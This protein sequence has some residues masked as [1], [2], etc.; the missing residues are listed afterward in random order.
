MENLIEQVATELSKKNAEKLAQNIIKE[1]K[2]C[3]IKMSIEMESL[4]KVVIKNNYYA[5]NETTK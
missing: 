2:E 3:D 1:L 5:I 4:L